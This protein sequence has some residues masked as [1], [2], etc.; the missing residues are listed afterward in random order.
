[1]LLFRLFKQLH[2]QRG[3][4]ASRH[5]RTK[6]L[7][8]SCLQTSVS[9][10]SES[11]PDAEEDGVQPQPKQHQA[12]IPPIVIYSYLNNHSAT[13]K[14]VNEKYPT[15]SML[16]RNPIDYSIHQ[17][18]SKIITCWSPK[19]VQLNSRTIRIH[20]RKMPNPDWF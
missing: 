16:N 4:G 8:D 18:F 13:L 7:H 12:R 14:Q 6:L 17:I 15:Q 3:N 10:L 20:Y 19:F 9:V 11:E 5:H 1:M 2:A